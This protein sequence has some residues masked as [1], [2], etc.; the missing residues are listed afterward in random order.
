MS[1][2]TWIKRDFEEFLGA[3]QD[4]T[5]STS[6][7]PWLSQ[8]WTNTDSVLHG[9]GVPQFPAPRFDVNNTTQ[10]VFSKVNYVD[11]NQYAEIVQRALEL[12][13]TLSLLNDGSFPGN[14]NSSVTLFDYVQY[15]LS[16]QESNE[17]K[18]TPWPVN[19]GRFDP[20]RLLL[21]RD[22]PGVTPLTLP[23]QQGLRDGNYVG[24]FPIIP[25]RGFAAVGQF[26]ISRIAWLNTSPIVSPTQ[27][28]FVRK[29]N[30]FCQPPIG[31]SAWPTLKDYP[32]HFN[33][34]VGSSFS[35]Q[36]SQ[37]NL[38]ETQSVVATYSYSTYGGFL[39][40]GAVSFPTVDFSFDSYPP[41]FPWNVNVALVRFFPNGPNGGNQPFQTNNRDRLIYLNPN[42]NNP[43][44]I[45]P[46]AHIMNPMFTPTYW[47]AVTSG[48]SSQD[49]TWST[50]DPRE[51]ANTSTWVVFVPAGIRV[52]LECCT[53]TYSSNLVWD[54][55]KYKPWPTGISDGNLPI[56]QAICRAGGYSFAY[57]P[58]QDCN[59]LT[60][61]YCN[62]A[63]PM[64][65]SSPN[66]V[67]YNTDKMLYQIGLCPPC[68]PS[69]VGMIQLQQVLRANMAC[70]YEPCKNVSSS[71]KNTNQVPLNGEPCP[72]IQNCIISGNQF[73]GDGGAELIVKCTT[74]GGGAQPPRIPDYSVSIQYFLFAA[75][76]LFFVIGGVILLVRVR[77]RRK[78][79]TRADRATS[80][81]DLYDDNEDLPSEYQY[82]FRRVK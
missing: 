52:S 58:G 31:N 13:P 9:A 54:W 38:T 28:L 14:N 60:E 72:D 29:D 76:F 74:G 68:P 25:P 26:V 55:S 33:L 56:S 81:Y 80:S 67:C 2:I 44:T 24:V 17:L 36:I 43:T 65:N 8:Q 35:R 78:S 51:T 77:K 64:F 37:P 6:Q 62:P 23:Y 34:R 71:L 3:Q 48:Y 53:G 27:L 1:N 16:P 30:R 61:A 45:A 66:C 57:K 70:V 5:K 41:C 75:A 21:R 10:A 32:T 47:Y 49:L 11:W 39:V 59:N 50:I 79:D 73:Y 22:Y 20:D 4:F 69:D 7:Y 18:S 19:G 63:L 12:N 42:T 46:T 15:M 82:A 40:N